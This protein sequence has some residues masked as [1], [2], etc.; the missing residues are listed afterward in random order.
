MIHDQAYI[1]QIKNSNES[2]SCQQIRL[3]EAN[4]NTI[5][6]LNQSNEVH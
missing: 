1:N 2:V 3:D 6:S 4:I 5:T